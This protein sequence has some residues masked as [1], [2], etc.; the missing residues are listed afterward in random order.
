MKTIEQ[1]DVIEQWEG[2]TER[3]SLNCGI[4]LLPC[5]YSGKRKSTA[6]F[7]GFGHN[8]SKRREDVIFKGS[9]IGDL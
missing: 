1:C 9:E 7:S 8:K 2:Y 4:W 5:F 3:G 6:Y